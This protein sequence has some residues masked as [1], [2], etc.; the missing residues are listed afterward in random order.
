MTLLTKKEI[1]EKS[2]AA[3]KRMRDLRNELYSRA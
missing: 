1:F 3:E 2:K